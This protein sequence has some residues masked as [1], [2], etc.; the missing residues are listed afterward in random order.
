[1]A[2]GYFLISFCFLSLYF[3]TFFHNTEAQVSPLWIV[4]AYFL[5]SFAELLI[6]ALGVAMVTRIAPERLYGVM[7]GTWFLV[8]QGLASSI[9]GIFANFASVPKDVTDHFAIL[10]IYSH[11]FLEFGVIAIIMAFIGLAINPYIKH[12]AKLD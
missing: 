4:L 7:M 5:Y 11:A 2:L 12:I 1:M 9:S 6:S 3:S 10:H 8:G